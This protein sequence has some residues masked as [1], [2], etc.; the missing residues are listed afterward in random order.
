MIALNIGKVT[1]D[2]TIPMDNFPVENSK[3]IL[4]EKLEASGGSASNVAY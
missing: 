2:T 1:Y 4:N 3:N